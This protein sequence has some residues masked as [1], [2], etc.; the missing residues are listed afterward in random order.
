LLVLVVFT[1]WLRPHRF[2][3]ARANDSAGRRPFTEHSIEGTWGFSGDFGMIVPPAVPQPVPT[4]ALGTVFFDGIGGCSVTNTVNI[5]G[6]IIGPMTS[7]TC[8]YS[9]NPDSTGTGVAEFSEAP[10]GG[11]STVTYGPR[12][13]PL[14]RGL[15]TYFTRI[16]SVPDAGIRLF[17][18]G[19]DRL[20][21]ESGNSGR[22]LELRLQPAASNFSSRFQF[23]HRVL[24]V[25]HHRNR[26]QLR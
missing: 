21:E 1:L 5:N 3:E 26:S 18:L 11:P 19:L 7:D 4:A 15:R 25:N 12:S 22:Y 9:V 17:D 10:F 23:L 8:I 13:G 16:C 6:T 24:W 14:T 2:A 20:I